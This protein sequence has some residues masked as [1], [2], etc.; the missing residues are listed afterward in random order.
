MAALKFP[1]MRSSAIKEIRD[2]LFPLADAE[3]LVG[4]SSSFFAG[5]LH[6]AGC[7]DSVHSFGNG[8]AFLRNVDSEHNIVAGL[9]YAVFPK[10][11]LVVFHPDAAGGVISFQDICLH[12]GKIGFGIGALC[13]L[14][15]LV[16][17]V[18]PATKSNFESFCLAYYRFV[19]D[20]ELRTA[21]YNKKFS[22][23]KSRLKAMG[24]KDSFVPEFKN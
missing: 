10:T 3:I 15:M 16:N 18:S 14:L 21:M 11:D 12:T 6:L 8:N 20:D 4:L 1:Y 23:V 17:R 9:N 2:S 19:P 7:T 13:A 22:Q 24:Y 5:E